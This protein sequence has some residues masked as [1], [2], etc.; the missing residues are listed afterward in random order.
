MEEILKKTFDEINNTGKNYFTCGLNTGFKKLD[1]ATSGLKRGNL[2]IIAGV[3]SIG[4]TALTLSIA[5]NISRDSKIPVA[6][7]SMNETETELCK[8]IIANNAQVAIEYIN[9]CYL[10]KNDWKQLDSAIVIMSK[11]RFFIKDGGKWELDDLTKNIKEM[12][13]TNKVE[14]VFIDT[15]QQ[16][17]IS[18]MAHLP[19]E[20]MVSQVVRELK[21]LAKE[22][23]IPIVAISPL[24]RGGENTPPWDK[25]K[26]SQLRE[27]GE[28]ENIADIV[29]FIHRWNYWR[30]YE[31]PETGKNL[32]N[33]AEIIIAKNRNGRTTEFDLIHKLEF[34]KFLNE[35]DVNST[36]S[37]S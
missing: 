4:K 21:S 8:K 25:P 15:L 32:K 18:K 28:I 9:N 31:N 7:Y 3:P 30:I 26:L 22:L 6:Y 2:I 5:N 33:I 1:F 16:I 12:V 19:R 11:M 29:L 14:V 17:Y 27:S 10:D 24:N 35:E 20:Q 36:A 13:E 37:Q 34:A 23:N